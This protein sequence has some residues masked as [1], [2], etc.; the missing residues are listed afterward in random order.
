VELEH[1]NLDR[2]GEGWEAVREGVDNE[3]G[4]PTYLQRFAG[5]LA[6]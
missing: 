2:H 1:R 4:W 6:R 5:V 3:G